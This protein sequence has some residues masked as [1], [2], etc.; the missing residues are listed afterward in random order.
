[1]QLLVGNGDAEA[2]VFLLHELLVEKLLDGHLADDIGIDVL[3]LELSRE[4]LRLFLVFVKFHIDAVGRS[5]SV[6][7]AEEAAARGEEV[8][9]NESEQRNDDNCEK[10]H[11]FAA[12]FL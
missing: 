1:M 3:A 9:E 4:L 8:T 7:G 12:D 2:V 6:A 11:R 10:Y 5:H